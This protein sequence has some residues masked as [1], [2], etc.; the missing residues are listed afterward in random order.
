MTLEQAALSAKKSTLVGKRPT[1]NSTAVRF[2]VPAPTDTELFEQFKEIVTTTLQDESVKVLDGESICIQLGGD[3]FKVVAIRDGVRG[4]LL[5]E[6]V[7][8]F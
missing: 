7:V 3:D 1:D 2:V 6:D 8:N 5:F 4:T